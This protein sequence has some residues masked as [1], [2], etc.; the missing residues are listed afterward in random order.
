MLRSLRFAVV[1]LFLLALVMMT[2][3]VSFADGPLPPPVCNPFQQPP[4]PR[5]TYSPVPG[6][7]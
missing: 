4:D 2:A 1:L 6:L 7:R 3:P 5:C